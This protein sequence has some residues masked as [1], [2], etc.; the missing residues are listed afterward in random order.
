MKSWR[1]LGK[2]K[3][4]ADAAAATPLSP[5]VQK[6]LERL[7]PL[8]G[9]PGSL[10]QEGLLAKQELDA[11]REQVA[12]TLGCHADEIIFTASGTEANNLAI[13]GALRPLLLKHGEVG[14]VTSKIEHQSVLEPLRALEREGLYVTELAVDGEG[15][16]VPE[17]LK[18]A[19]SDETVFISIQLINSEVG[20][21]QRIKEIAKIVRRVRKERK[22]SNNPLPLYLHT[23]AA[24]A[25]LWL[26][27][28]MESLGI[29]MLSLDGQKIMGPKGVGM[30]YVRRGV[31]LE[32]ILW[33]GMQERGFRAGT[34]NVPL[35]GAFAV[36][37]LHAQTGVAARREQV[38]AVRDA[39]IAEIEKMF[40]GANINGVRGKERA[41]NN[42]NVSVPGLM[43]EMAVIALAADGVAV[44]TRSACSSDDDKTSH[45]LEALGIPL[46]REEEAIRITLLPDASMEDGRTIAKAL[47]RVA[48]TYK[49][50]V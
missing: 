23:D 50:M 44:S 20:T 38:Q 28:Q 22:E 48:K 19:I 17:Q 4:Y 25:P 49:R 31:A 9:N 8:F 14:A 11:A 1:N 26:E 47:E 3:V 2:K 16:V 27:L 13:A 39:L 21:I 30:L 34:E 40:A 29:D 12:T 15:F 37:L 45:V 41:P 36:A 6:E 24:Q 33:G 35:V 42:V 10:H 18:E 32:P 5:A 43:G 46:Q 7:L